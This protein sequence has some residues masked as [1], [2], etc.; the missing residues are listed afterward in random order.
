MRASLNVIAM[1]IT[2]CNATAAFADED[3]AARID[4]S[5]EAIKSFAG[6]L[7]EQ[8]MSAT[9][10]GGPTAA[11]EVCK[12]AAPDIAEEASDVWELAALQDFEARKAAGEHPDTLDR[13]EFVV[14]GGQRT[15]R[16]LKA[17]STQPVCT[18]CHGAGIAPEVT[19]RLAAL[20]P[21]DQARGFEVG[22]IRGA[23]SIAQPVP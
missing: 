22:D 9:A 21:D 18:L 7:Q 2:L 8:L 11:I 13:A 23:F 14:S 6:A 16:Y 1:A 4:A 17:I 10:V 12:I 3:L 15:F 20:Y 5:R 19:A